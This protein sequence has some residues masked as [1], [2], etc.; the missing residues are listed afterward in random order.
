MGSQM[1][2][3]VEEQERLAIRQRHRLAV[4][5]VATER[6][7]LVVPPRPLGSLVVELETQSCELLSPA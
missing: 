7:E 4:S 3:P 5:R 6:A 1:G 2:T